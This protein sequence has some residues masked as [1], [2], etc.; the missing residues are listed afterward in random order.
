[1]RFQLFLGLGNGLK[2]TLVEILRGT[3]FSVIIDESTY[4]TIKSQLAV[5]VQYWNIKTLTL[6]VDVLDFVVCPEATADGLS[7][8]VLNLLDNMQIPLKK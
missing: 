1:M 3:F 5:M 2:K 4:I 7:R 8:A 6:A